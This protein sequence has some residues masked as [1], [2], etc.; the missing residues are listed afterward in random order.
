MQRLVDADRLIPVGQSL[1]YVYYHDDFPL[2]EIANIWAETR[3][4][5]DKLY[6]VQ[7]DTSIIERCILMT[8]DPGDLVFDPTCVRKGTRVLAPLNPPV[9]GGTPPYPPPVNGGTP[10]YPPPVN[11]G[12]PLCDPPDI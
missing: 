7:T 4:A 1:D 11:G 12:T 5:V 6:S 10:P 2:T 9:N 8:T 3:G